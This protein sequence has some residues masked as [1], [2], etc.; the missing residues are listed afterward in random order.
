MCR[1]TH[2]LEEMTPYIV[3]PRIA[4]HL[5]NPEQQETYVTIPTNQPTK[6]TNKQTYISPA[7][8]PGQLRMGE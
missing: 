2:K 8:L 4:P 3:K 5:E 6:Q 7:A 1:L